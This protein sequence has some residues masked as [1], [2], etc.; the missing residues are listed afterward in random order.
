MFSRT[1]SRAFSVG[2]VVRTPQ[3]TNLPPEKLRALIS[4]YHQA[5]S[6]VT[7]ENLEAKIDEAFLTQDM[8]KERLSHKHLER[9]LQKR[10]DAAE[11][12]E[13]YPHSQEADGWGN[14]SA[15]RDVQVMEALYG[16]EAVGSEPALP[17]LE[18]L[19][20]ANEPQ[21]TREYPKSDF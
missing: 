12:T 19:Q 1:L 5:Q 15:L 3:T 14:R 20:D 9:L 2:N 21:D 13:W 6:F 16:V 17:A 10:Q 4:I 18:S 8:F 11:V 7:R